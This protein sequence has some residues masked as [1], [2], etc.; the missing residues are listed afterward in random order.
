MVK[1]IKQLVAGDVVLGGDGNP[2]MSVT[3]V[4]RSRANTAIIEGVW[5]APTERDG[6][7]TNGRNTSYP[8]GRTFSS[9]IEVR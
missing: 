8:T 7:R 4:L 2:M 1:Q 3:C 9:I 6:S 5:L